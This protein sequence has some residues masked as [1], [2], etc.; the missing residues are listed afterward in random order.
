MDAVTI[1]VALYCAAQT[2]LAYASDPNPE[3]IANIYSEQA[4]VDAHDAVVDFVNEAADDATRTP[5]INLV[6]TSDREAY[7]FGPWTAREELGAADA[8]ENGALTEWARHYYVTHNWSEYGQQILTILPYDQVSINGT[9][10]TVEAIFDY[11]QS[12][13]LEE[14]EGIVGESAYCL[15]TCIPDSDLVRVVYGR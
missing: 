9:V 13:Y 5:P 10:F 12:C 2:S 1:I 15:Q 7:F 6:T 3:V 4:V 11:P 14:V 8:D